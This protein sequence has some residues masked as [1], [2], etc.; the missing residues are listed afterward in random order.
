M[1]MLRALRVIVLLLIG[2]PVAL[3]E[4]AP[5]AL[6]HLLRARAALGDAHWSAIL[7]LASN[8]PARPADDALVFEFA[9]ALWMYRPLDGTQSLSRHWNNVAAERRNL[10]PLLQR[11]DADYT[12]FGEY[13]SL[14]LAA[15]SPS[16][17]ELPN[18]CF[19]QSVAEA[20][21]LEREAAITDG[22]LLSYYADTA[23]GQQG[24]TVLVYQDATGSHVFDPAEGST[25]DTPKTSLY[26]E[27][28][29]LARRITP[30]ALASRL[31][32]AAKIAL[33]SG[34][35]ENLPHKASARSNNVRPTL[36]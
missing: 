26:D 14:A 24:H 18:G 29:K 33:F 35:G 30:F 3:G 27:A 25:T 9:N 16:T 15:T 23:A 6:S 19:I 8:D 31:T 21:R 11:I 13:D 12:S 7:R 36:R 20:R 28:L 1:K 32:K 10:L 4:V 5:A 17:G 34:A 22:C 2:L